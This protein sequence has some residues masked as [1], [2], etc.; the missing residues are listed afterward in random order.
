M[1]ESIIGEVILY[2][3]AIAAVLSF[4]FK[5]HIV[6]FIFIALIVTNLCS[7]FKVVSEERRVK[8]GDP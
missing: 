5:F 2:L 4:G 7:L 1:R 6:G 3:S 8:R